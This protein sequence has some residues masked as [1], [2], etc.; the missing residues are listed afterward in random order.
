MNTSIIT[1]ITMVSAA[2]TI[3][4]TTMKMRKNMNTSII[5]TITM[6]NAAIMIMTIIMSMVRTAPVDVMTMTTIITIIMQTRYLEAGVWKLRISTVRKSLR[7]SLKPLGM[8]TG[9]EWFF[10]PRVWFPV[11]KADSFTL[12]MFREKAISV[13]ASRM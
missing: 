2:I 10:V 4:T 13:R 1:T 6:V 3:M 12:T 9:M 7:R 5:T 8:M 11:P